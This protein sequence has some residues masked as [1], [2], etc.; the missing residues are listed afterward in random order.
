MIS[1]IYN[2]EINKVH[3]EYFARDPYQHI[4]LSHTDTLLNSIAFVSDKQNALR[5]D[6]HNELLEW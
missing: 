2:D 4:I 3:L 1:S 6:Q 5:L